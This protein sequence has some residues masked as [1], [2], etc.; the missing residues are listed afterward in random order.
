MHVYARLC[1]SARAY[2]AH[3]SLRDELRDLLASVEGRHFHV[4]H[5]P[6]GPAGRIQNLVMFLQDLTETGEIQ[7]LWTPKEALLKSIPIHFSFD[8]GFDWIL[9]I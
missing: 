7:I 1:T 8:F 2:V 9:N 3:L 6:V 4:S 5:T